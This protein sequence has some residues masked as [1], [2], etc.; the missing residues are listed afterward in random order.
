MINLQFCKGSF[1][2]HK[3]YFSIALKNGENVLNVFDRKTKHIQKSRA[4]NLENFIVYDYLKEEVGWRVADRILDINRKF[5]NVVDLGCGRGY[6]S[7]HMLADSVENLVMCDMNNSTLEQASLPETGVNVR[8]EVV[9][10]EEL[11]FEEGSL[12]L[13]VSSLTLHWV[14]DLPSSFK[15]V[16]QSLKNDGAFLGALFGGD[17]LYE[18][19]SSLQLADS[20]RLGGLSSHIS[21]FTMINDIGGLLSQA[22][23]RLITMD[24]DELVIGYPSMFELIWDLKGMGENNCTWN[25]CKHLNREVMMAA[26]AI[27][28]QL[29]GSE[30]K[31]PATF[32]IIYFLGWKPDASQPK[33][34]ERGSAKYSLKNIGNITSG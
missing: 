3:R 7:K 8:K 24:T 12:D 15:Q 31:I 23:F 26:A 4:S 6:I 18:L 11:P 29:Y 5:K 20:E 19:R 14:N 28:N 22:G 33:P 34:L 25:R 32:Q 17:T 27:Y 13:V 10:E 21:P 2:L 30:G 9:N 16:I 1:L